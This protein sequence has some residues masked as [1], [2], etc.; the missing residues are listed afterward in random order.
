LVI[1]SAKPKILIITRYS[2]GYQP[3]PYH[4]CRYLSEYYDI[5]CLCLDDTL[6]R[7]PISLKGVKTIYVHTEFGKL[8]RFISLLRESFRTIRVGF[9]LCIVM[10]F[11]G[12]AIFKIFNPPSSKFI[13]DIQSGA[14]GNSKTKRILD[15]WM[16]RFEAS[17][18]RY[19][20][21]LSESLRRK[22]HMS[23]A[24][25]IPIGARTISDKEGSF[26]RMDLIYVGTLQNR[27]IDKTIKGFSQFYERHKDMVGMSYTIIGN[28][29][30]NE[31]EEL[32]KLVRE[33]GLEGI[34]KIAGYVAT[35]KLAPFFNEANVGVSFIPLTDYYD[36]QPPTKTFEYLLSGMPVIATQ[37]SENRN[38]VDNT[39]G[40][41]IEDSPAGFYQGLM[42]LYSR[43]NT[44][45]AKEIRTRAQ[46]HT[47]EHITT[48]RLI[49]FLKAVLQ[50]VPDK[51][52][53]EHSAAQ[54]KQRAYNER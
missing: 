19:K 48:Q 35:N 51:H 10:Y 41:L 40:V 43:R 9:D 17:F 52:M 15:N 24:Y 18:F 46:V 1:E 47:W 38:L 3:L 34:V 33:E 11:P 6:G 30:K 13:L 31:E 37:T 5:T 32:K 39:N 45:N 25:V 14:I 49:P 36:V 7:E 20:F 22:L 4:W 12:C 50:L 28:G 53:P 29:Y 27:N 26:K 8:S 44:F 54:A 2:F 23:T 21:V 16:L 42:E